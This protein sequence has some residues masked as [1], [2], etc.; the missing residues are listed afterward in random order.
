[1]DTNG[2]TMKQIN[3]DQ[4]FHYETKKTGHKWF[5]YE[6]KYGHIW[7]HYETKK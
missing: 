5:H 6:I 3:G 7:S 1:M 4:W 2:F